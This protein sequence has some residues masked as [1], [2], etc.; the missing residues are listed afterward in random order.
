MTALWTADALLAA[1]GGVMATPFEVTGI[2]IDTRSLQPGDLFVAL[3]GETDGH[4]HVAEALR[5]G[6]AGA[7][8][9]QDMNGP[10]LRVPDTMAALQALG[11][12][13]RARFQ[14]RMMAVTGSVGKTTTKEMLRA[15]LTAF[16]PTH[17]AAASYNNHWGVPLTLARLP[18]DAT[19]CV[20]EIGMNHPGEVLPLAQMVAPHVA[21]ITLIAAAH[22]GHLGSL[23]AI[24]DEKASLLDALPPDGVA[25]LPAEDAFFQRLADR[26]GSRVIRTFGTGGEAG[27]R[28]LSSSEDVLADVRGVPVRFHLAAKGAHM[29]RNAAAALAACAAL[30]LDPVR[31]AAALDGFAPVTG[32]GQF[33]SLPSGITLLDESYNA[34]TASVRAA[35]AVLRE[36]PG[37]RV[38]VL[39]DMLELGI[40]GPGEH[41]K[42]A[43]PVADSAELLFACGPLMR[44]LYQEVPF[45]QRGGYALDSASLVPLVEAGL[46][47][48]DTVLVKGSL[49]SQ[50]RVVVTALEGRAPGGLGLC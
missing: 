25:V 28:I 4:V 41:A 48:G 26:A 47:A 16:G 5:R 8:V 2:S 9:H 37:R 42:L 33:R 29:A 24:A 45:S 20:A 43:E 31:A 13:G 21:I 30:G 10:V 14:G 44:H 22:I 49:G 32:R 1:T 12:T 18:A 11:R 40:F 39:G 46:R 38:A 34:S 7:L 6:A 35:L 19:F 50:M 17:A 23:E 36:L 3:Q 27:V 15:C